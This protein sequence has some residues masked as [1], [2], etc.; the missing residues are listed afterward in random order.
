MICPNPG[1]T[2]DER[3][4]SLLEVTGKIGWA[5]D[6]ALLYGK[7]G[8]GQE[9]V[10]STVSPTFAGY[11]DSQNL[12]GLILGAGLEYAFWQNWTAGLEYIHL[13]MR[14]QTF[15]SGQPAGVVR[16]VSGSDNLV[17][18]VLNYRFMGL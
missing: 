12:G 17:R 4:N 16:N 10:K 7:V 3:A 14:G 18:A 6:R 2:C 9:H 8:W 13:D 15:A 1:F 5:W 11:D